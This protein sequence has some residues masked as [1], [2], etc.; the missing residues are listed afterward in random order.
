MRSSGS[1]FTVGF[2][3][4]WAA[5]EGSPGQRRAAEGRF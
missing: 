1:L 3:L 2:S 5:A 4:R